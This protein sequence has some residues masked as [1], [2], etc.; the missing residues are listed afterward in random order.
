MHGEQWARGF[1]GALTLAVLGPSIVFWQT[2]FP[3]A[4]L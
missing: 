3:E 2:G 4:Y 1:G